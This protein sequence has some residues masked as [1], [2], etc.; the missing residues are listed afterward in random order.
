MGET[1]FEAHYEHVLFLRDSTGKFRAGFEGSG[2][3]L[4]E[5]SWT[6]HGEM[7]HKKMWKPDLISSLVVINKATNFLLHVLSF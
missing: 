7:K 2:E 3:G 5:S 1:S 6:N 4:E